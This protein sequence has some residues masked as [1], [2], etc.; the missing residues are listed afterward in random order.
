MLW[1]GEDRIIIC[2]EGKNAKQIENLFC[3]IMNFLSSKGRGDGE[4]FWSKVEKDI[5][6]EK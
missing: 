2:S 5:G 1:I 6:K 3:K 4:I